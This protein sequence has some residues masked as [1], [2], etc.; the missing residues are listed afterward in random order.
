MSLKTLLLREAVFYLK[1]VKRVETR[2]DAHYVLDNLFIIIIKR[3][4][5]SLYPEVRGAGTSRFVRW[6]P[7]QR[8][9]F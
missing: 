3:K 9:G 6:T 2:C 5:L 8:S 4:I 7:D 1:T